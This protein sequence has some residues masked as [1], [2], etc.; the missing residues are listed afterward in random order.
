MTKF[1]YDITNILRSEIARN[2]A[3]AKIFERF[4]TRAYKGPV[5][6]FISHHIGYDM[7]VKPGEPRHPIE[8]PSAD[9]LLFS[10]A[11][12]SMVF[13]ESAGSI[14]RALLLCRPEHREEHLERELDTLDRIE[15]IRAERHNFRVN[16][17]GQVLEGTI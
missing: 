8:V 15:Q 14:M 11:L 5:H 3:G 2:E 1:A 10:H 4:L 12:M 17:A 13:G 9:T 16:A 7:P 6:V